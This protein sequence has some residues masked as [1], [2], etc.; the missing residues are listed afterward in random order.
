MTIS[1]RLL[2]QMGAAV[3]GLVLVAAM[4]VYQI[5]KVY[6]VTNVGNVDGIHS[7]L[8]LAKATD[9]L[10][11]IRVDYWKHIANDD[12][13]RKKETEADIEVQLKAFDQ[14]LNTY[15]KNDISDDKD[16]ALLNADR[17]EMAR[18]QLA[19]GQILE[20]SNNN[21]QVEA[22]ALANTSPATKLREALQAHAQY[23]VEF[24][25][26]A[27]KDAQATKASAFAMAA[28]ITVLTA[29]AVALLGF[30]VYRR[31]NSGLNSARQTIASIGSSLDF[32]MRSEVKG[33]DEIAQTLSA[34]NQLIERLQSNLRTLQSEVSEVA[35]TSGELL[36]ASRQV[37]ESSATQSES[38]SHMAASVEQMT[39][40]I[41]HVAERAGEASQ[42]SGAA[43]EN[44]QS[45]QQVIG[46][47]VQD[48]HAIAQ[49]VEAVE[50]DLHALESDSREIEVV[51][52]VVREVADQTNLLALNAAIEAAR[53][54]EAGRGFAVVAD[55][56]RQL[57]ERTTASTREISAKI[58]AIQSASAAAVER[59]HAAVQ[60]VEQGVARAS[61][62]EQSMAVIFDSSGQS[63]RLVSEISDAIREQ[64]GATNA[65][66]VQVEKVARMAEEN[67]GAATQ[68]AAMAQRLE[69]I[70][71]NMRSIVAAYRL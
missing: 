58:T 8:D 62:A 7:V 1:K 2:L 45:G 42:L 71:G 54:G 19:L 16:R 25:N 4:G 17:A 53:A 6:T 52:K 40:S 61:S 30:T 65:I 48:I 37:A 11:K 64:G 51:V 27:S 14:A 55:E 41:N 38:S 66:S 33:N 12:P 63:V 23:N 56:V 28:G 70:S 57:A 47:T 60:R 44:A 69:E 67:S 49:A 39:V 20:L 46:Q 24:C 21:K 29:L 22:Q 50:Q 3:L 13:A 18:F 59:M 31:V 68:A 36:G 35:Q 34:F 5:D 26:K 32:T 9:V 15:E 10:A 43:G